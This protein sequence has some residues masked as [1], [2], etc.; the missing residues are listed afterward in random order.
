MDKKQFENLCKRLKAAAEDLALTVC[1]ERNRD[2]AAAAQSIREHTKDILKAN[3]K[4]VCLARESGM[5]EALID[6]LSLDEKKIDGMISQVYSVISQPDPLGKGEGWCASNGMIIR[7]ATVP[8]GVAA[9]I[10]ESRPN[11]TLDVFALC[12]KSGNAVLLRGSKGA[13]RS[14]LA[15]VNA[16]K[17]GISKNACDLPCGR[18]MGD[19]RFAEGAPQAQG[20][21]AASG[22]IADCISLMEPLDDH[23]DVDMILQARGLIDVAVPRGGRKLIEHVVQNAKVPTIETG[24]GI[25]HLYVDESADI[26]MAAI[27]AR[28]AKMSRPGVCNAIECILIHRGILHDFLPRLLKA[29]DGKVELRAD[30][31]CFQLLSPAGNAETSALALNAAAAVHAE[32]DD[33][34]TEFLDLIC[35]IHV[36]GSIGE[37]IDFINQHGTGHS[38]CIITESLPAAKLFEARVNAACVYVNAST[39]FTDGGEF[40]FGA[41]LGISTQKLHTRGPMGAAA[42]T[43]VKYLIE[44]NGQ[45]R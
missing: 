10:Y 41:E 45:V 31:E 44:G 6:R 17:A 3:S 37:A 42:L 26:D 7:R 29:F 33:W 32:D 11:V 36:V 4:D 38:E 30:E 21:G 1:E 25:C 14:N 28:N 43:T 40:G 9:V 19:T 5:S 12:H 2:L 8:L 18:I 24:S 34:D 23:S 15:I 39:R 20:A 35:A 27:I 13:Y 16:I 22:N